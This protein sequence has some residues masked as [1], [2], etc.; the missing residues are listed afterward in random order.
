M[1]ETRLEQIAYT[2]Q[3]ATPEIKEC[4]RNNIQKISEDVLVVKEHSIVTE[5]SINVMFDAMEEQLLFPHHLIVDVSELKIPGTKERDLMKVR[6]SKVKDLT[7]EVVIITGQNKILNTIAKLVL[8]TVGMKVSK[9]CSNMDDAL[10]FISE[11]QQS[12]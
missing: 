9:F 6:L 2:E 11:K 3:N 1:P 10:Q 5:F 8:M 12:S 7:K 4:L